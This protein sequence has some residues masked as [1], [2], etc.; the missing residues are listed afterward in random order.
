MNIAMGAARR[1]V[2]PAVAARGVGPCAKRGR[3]PVP[4]GAPAERVQVANVLEVRAHRSKSDL[5]VPDH[6]LGHALDVRR[7]DGIDTRE[8]F[9]KAHAPAVHQRAALASCGSTQAMAQRAESGKEFLCSK[10][11]RLMHDAGTRPVL[12]IYRAQASFPDT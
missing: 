8:S 6:F 2:W 4:V 9:G 10:A 5:L 12:V 1:A 7:F 3:V 11:D